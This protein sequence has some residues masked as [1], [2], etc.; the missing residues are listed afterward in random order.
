MSLIKNLLRNY[1]LVNKYKTI[2]K[3]ICGN[4]YKKPFIKVYITEEQIS[5][6]VM[7]AKYGIQSEN[8]LS[9]ILCDYNKPEKNMNVRQG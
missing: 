5:L 2:F 9:K 8:H 7:C 4:K 3:V 1:Y 6:L